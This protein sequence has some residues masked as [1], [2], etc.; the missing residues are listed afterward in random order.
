V[1]RD[2]AVLHLGRVHVVR[3]G[4]ARP[5]VGMQAAGRRSGAASRAAR[6]QRTAHAAV[7]YHGRAGRAR[8][9]FPG[10]WALRARYAHHVRARTSFKCRFCADS[11]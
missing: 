4:Q 6:P 5:G 8:R 2:L 7:P 1:W 11:Y 10:V 9:A 3:V